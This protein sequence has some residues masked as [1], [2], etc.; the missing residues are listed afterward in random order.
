VFLTVANLRG[1]PYGFDLFGAPGTRPYGMLAH[2]DHVCFAV[3]R[4]GAAVPGTRPQDPALAPNG[5]W[6]QLALAALA[7][8]AFPIGLRPRTLEREYAD[9]HGRF[10]Q[11]PNWPKPMPPDPYR[12]LCVDG[13]LMNNEPLEVARHYLSDGGRNP[14]SGM[15]AHRAVIMIDPFPNIAAFDP[16]YTANDGLLAVAGRM[17]GALVNQARFKPEELDLA[18]DPNVYSRFSIAPSRSG[19][20]SRGI[21]PAMASAILGGFG[22]FLCEAFRRHDFQLGRRN[23]QR[24][25][26]QHFCLPE[27]NGLFDAWRDSPAAEGF[28]VREDGREGTG[29]YARFTDADPQRMLPIIP[30]MPE[31]ADEIELYRPPTAGSV[32][33]N[34]LEQRL[35]ARLK[36][37]SSALVDH[38]LARVVGNRFV[39]WLVRTGFD[40]LIGPRLLD[41]ARDTVVAELARL[42]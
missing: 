23:C 33:V 5:K 28:Y 16:D 39:R 3:S 37:L 4:T 12:M 19:A 11:D 9:Y 21:E 8:G 20:G 2:A 7:T 27:R 29:G 17:F 41:K 18:E 15:E 40:F 34:D 6:P 31:V 22:G 35:E 26:K 38:D 1:V 42:R 14:R 13:G 36:A 10:H 32:K 25:L 30:L 24:F